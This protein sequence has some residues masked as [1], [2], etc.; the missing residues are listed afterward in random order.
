M[1]HTQ[2]GSVVVNSLSPCWPGQSE[3]PA[4]PGRAGV[5]LPAEAAPA[6]SPAARSSPSAAVDGGSTI[7]LMFFRFFRASIFCFKFSSWELLIRIFGLSV[8]GESPGAGCALRPGERPNCSEGLGSLASAGGLGG[9][10]AGGGSSREWRFDAPSRG[11]EP[12]APLGTEW[13]VFG[14]DPMESRCCLVGVRPSGASASLIGVRALGSFRGA[15]S[16]WILSGRDFHSCG[17]CSSRSRAPRWN[18]S[19]FSSSSKPT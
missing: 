9:V 14:L 12:T 2:S 5:F 18:S 17:V 6:W 4:L 10:D 11:D 13:P 1:L 16:G 19:D 8:A 15:G 7:G 3:R